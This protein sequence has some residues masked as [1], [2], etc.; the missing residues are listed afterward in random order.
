[1]QEWA[2]KRGSG[3]VIEV[4]V[5]SSE[6]VVHHHSTW[7]RHRMETFSAL[8]AICAG[9]SP[10]P[11]NSPHKGQW[12]GALMFSLIC[13]RIN[14]WVNNREVGDLRR[15]RPQYDVIVMKTGYEEPW[16]RASRR[17]LATHGPTIFTMLADI[18]NKLFPCISAIVLPQILLLLD[19]IEFGVSFVCYGNMYAVP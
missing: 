10:V 11:V 12:R 8:L 9:N 15:Y 2:V 17:P 6:E 18:E 7:W 1:M 3:A 4:V 16:S 19:P 5:L 13:A 14:S